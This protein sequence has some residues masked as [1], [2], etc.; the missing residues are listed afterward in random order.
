MSYL[1]ELTELMNDSLSNKVAL[2]NEGASKYTDEAIREAFFEIIGDD[3]LTWQ[4]FR[5]ND[6]VIYTLIENVLITNLPM[7]WENSRFYDQFVESRNAALGD[8]NEFVVDS[9]GLFVVSNFAGN[10]WS[11]DR[12]KIQGKK[13]FS[14]STSWI[15]IHVYNDLERF[16]KG[17]ITFPEMIAK[18]QRS[19]QNEID[20]R[21]YAA[22]N[23][24]GTYLPA[25]FKESGTYD[26]G[27]MNDLI[28]RVQTATQKDV[29]IAG[30]RTA[31]ANISEGINTAWI[32]ESQK[33]ELATTG[34]VVE[35]I[36]L[37]AKAIMI[38][39]TFLKGTYDF[40]VDNNVIHVL[41]ADSKLIKLFY[42]GDVRA[43]NLDEQQTNDMVISAQVQCKLGV[44]VVC[45]N[46]TGRYEI[47]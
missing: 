1:R 24:I 19:F 43:R 46:L 3:K 28:Q 37:P 20:G 16:L 39:Q 36:G 25:A 18:M 26:R 10:Y 15:Y 4:N 45:D 11:T 35:N 22:F 31:L 21:I 33:E 29:V 17:T 13:S 30:T 40:K 47:V 7:A 8:K 42:E 38:P 41:P 27:L 12:Q 2:F 32:A 5:N 23:G 44:G 6:R 34:V 14:V 9:D